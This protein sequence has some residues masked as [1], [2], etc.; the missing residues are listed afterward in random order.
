MDDMIQRASR[1]VHGQPIRD[2]SQ[3]SPLCLGQITTRSVAK[4][5][6]APEAGLGSVAYDDR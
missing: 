6:Q 2:G 4:L 1:W 5:R 3:D